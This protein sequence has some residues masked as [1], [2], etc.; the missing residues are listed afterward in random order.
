[1]KYCELKAILFNYEQFK[2]TC[3]IDVGRGNSGDHRTAIGR[4]NFQKNIGRRKFRKVVGRKKKEEE[5]GQEFVV[6]TSV[7]RNLA[8]SSVGG[9]VGR[10]SAGKKNR[11]IVDRRLS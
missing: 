9:N 5:R 6:R 2:S 4:R 10:L 8:K 7:G 11:K 3:R 1:M